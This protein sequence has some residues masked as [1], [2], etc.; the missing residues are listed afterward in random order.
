MIGNLRIAHVKAAAYNAKGNMSASI[1]SVC[2]RPSDAMD[3]IQ[4]NRS[5][6]VCAINQAIRVDADISEINALHF[7]GKICYVKAMKIIIRSLCRTS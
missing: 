7:A 5:C 2:A 4:H 3:L 6:L 1:K